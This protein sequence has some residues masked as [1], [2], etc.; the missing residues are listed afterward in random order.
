M[1]KIDIPCRDPYRAQ[2][3]SSIAGVSTFSF[4][5][6]G[7]DLVFEAF[8]QYKE[9]IGFVKAMNALRGM[10]LLYKDRNEDRAWTANI[11]VDFDR[12]KHLSDV[13]IKKRKIEREK[14]ISKE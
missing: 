9:Y 2:M 10:K 12:T 13:T 5:G 11:K 1:G 14:I 8:I 3:K 6:S 4:F 7:Q